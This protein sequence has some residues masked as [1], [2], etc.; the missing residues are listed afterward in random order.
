MSRGSFNL[1]FVR[2]GRHYVQAAPFWLS[3]TDAPQKS[4]MTV[5]AR[6]SAPV[7][8]IEFIVEE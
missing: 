3:A 6:E 8:N 7:E 4:S 5:E 2:A 1:K